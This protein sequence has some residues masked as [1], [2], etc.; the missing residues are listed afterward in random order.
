M[1]KY[2][3][4]LLSTFLVQQAIGQQTGSFDTTITFNGSARTL[5]NFVPANYNPLLPARLIVGLHG[6]GDN[7]A[8]YRGSLLN[9]LSFETAFPNTIL[10]CP[11]GGDD[12]N[13]DFYVPAGDEQIIMEAIAYAKS[14]YNIDTSNVI[15]QGFSLGGRSALRYGLDNTALFKALILNTPAIQGVKEA[16][17]Q[18]TVFN[19]NYANATELPIFI[20][21]GDDDALYI[22]PINI[23]VAHMVAQYGKVAYKVFSGGHNVPNFQNYAYSA[24]FD[25]PYSSGADAGIYKVNTP[26]RSCDGYVNASVLFQNTGDIVLDSARVLYGIGNNLDTFTWQGNLTQHE[27]VTIQLPSYEAG[28]LAANTYDF[29]VQILDLNQNTQDLF[30]DFNRAEGSVHI[31]TNSLNLPFSESFASASSMSGWA[32]NQS[33]DYSASLELSEEDEALS[34]LNTIFVFDNG[35]N[36]EEV[37]SPNLDMSAATT[38]YLHFDVDYNYVEYTSDVAAIDTVF[39]DTLEVLVSTDCGAT[40]TALFKKWGAD[41]SGHD[42]PIQNPLNIQ[43]IALD[44]DET[45]YRSFSLNVSQYTGHDNVS[46]KFS[47]ISALGGYI[48]LDNI[49]VNDKPADIDIMMVASETMNIYPNPSSGLITLHAEDQLIQ[50][51]RVYNLLGQIVYEQGGNKYTTQEI[52]LSHLPKGVYM[53]QAGFEGG[54]LNRKVVLR[55]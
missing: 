41:L 47:Y 8:S 46:F 17:N 25:Q 19:Y 29:T 28:N 36:R 22:E 44:K 53:L 37:I 49:G 14:L 11:D 48:Y 5:S 3:I 35:G 52:D 54:V 21:L 39:A 12:Q 18:S 26:V 7:S 45:K 20:T 24:F 9:S 23:A 43:S 27:S 34:G 13:S 38:A 33:G 1:K 15:L 50:Q 42:T 2:M 51:I 55:P 40:Y 16:R 30:E 4:L 6:L 10:V 31:M 32:L